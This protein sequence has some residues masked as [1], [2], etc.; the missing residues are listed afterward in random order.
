MFHQTS[1]RQIDCQI[2][3]FKKPV[4]DLMGNIF[5][6]QLSPFNERDLNNIDKLESIFLMSL[7]FFLVPKMV[8]IIELE[9]VCVVTVLE[10]ECAPHLDHD[11]CRYLHLP[12]GKG[13]A[14]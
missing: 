12:D 13:K 5:Y 11:G 9:S 10:L 14:G 3:I 8:A 1:D 6:P 4:E 7:R 2:F